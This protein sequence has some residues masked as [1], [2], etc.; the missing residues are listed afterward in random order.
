ISYWPIIL[1]LN[2]LFEYKIKDNFMII[3]KRS[4]VLGILSA[5]QFYLSV[6]LAIF[7]LFL[8][9]IFFILLLLFYLIEK[10]IEVFFLIKNFFSF[11]ITYL[12]F[13]IVSYPLIDG[14]LNFQK[15]Y[16]Q[17]R[18]INEILQN[19][20]NLTDYVFFLPNT[21]FSNLSWIKK[22]NN[23]CR[24]ANERTSFPGVV[25]FLGSIGGIFFQKIRKKRRGFEVLNKLNFSYL[26]FL[27]LIIIGFVFS[28]GPRLVANGKYL[29]IP[30]P[31][32]IFLKFFDFLYSIR[33]THRW[34][35][36]MV[37]GLSYFSAFFYSKIKN[38]IFLL[39]VIIV[40]VLESIPKIKA[41]KIN[42]FSP[43]H[44][45]LAKLNEKNKILLE[46]PFLNL[47]KGVG[48]TVETSRLLSS[49]YHQ[50]ILFNG[51][52]GIFIN[53]Y[54]MMRLK[55]EKYFPDEQ[56]IKAIR[57]LNI[58]YLKIDKK[59]LKKTDYEKIKLFLGKPFYEDENSSF[60]KLK[61]DS[62]LTS[63]KDI[64]IGF[65]KNPSYGYDQ[66]LY[67]DL[68]F[69]NLNLIKS[70]S[71]INQEKIILKLFFYQN[72]KLIK[73]KEIYQLYPL[74]ISSG[75]KKE[76]T[77]QLFEKGRFNKIK[78]DIYNYKQQKIS[79]TSSGV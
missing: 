50:M 79:S 58:D 20:G 46:Y 49:V 28:L 48:I 14:Y 61:K 33:L 3:F 23:F 16:H 27:L 70:Y 6:Y 44:K 71:N 13:I 11:L 4:L 51:Y 45:F 37:I 24:F 72:D 67:L 41:E 15:T 34:S 55:M 21:F 57:A 43:A 60:F 26:F 54:G 64:K 47:E 77:I 75:E 35:I 17:I 1:N 30:L 32:L 7:N 19:S 12:V 40:F 39:I 42:Y 18:D 52:T 2:I 22:F 62:N 59:F 25:I 53:D 10:K 78:V 76:V 36:L 68:F 73:T 74:I 66:K 8:I 31:Y 69:K 38:K 5:F 56:T 29:E 65:S 63:S 9:N